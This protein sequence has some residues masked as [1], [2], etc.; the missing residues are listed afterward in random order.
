MLNSLVTFIAIR[1]FIL[2]LIL[3]TIVR[4]F[5]Q[6]PTGIHGLG[7]LFHFAD[8]WRNMNSMEVFKQL[9]RGLV[10]LFALR[11][12]SLFFCPLLY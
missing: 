11:L 12:T 1:N 7:I 4:I 6:F 3:E 9:T 10:L 8:L 5:I 2:G